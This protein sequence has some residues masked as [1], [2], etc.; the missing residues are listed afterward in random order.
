MGHRGGEKTAPVIVCG[1]CGSAVEDGGAYVLTCACERLNFHYGSE[2]FAGMWR[3]WPDRRSVRLLMHVG[4]EDS[5]G[6]QYR[7][8]EPSGGL[9]RLVRKGRE[10]ATVRRVVA[11]TVVRSVFDT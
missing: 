10:S 7:L 1:V 2:P 9:F 11:E 8:Y 6:R 5:T 4:Y 3:F